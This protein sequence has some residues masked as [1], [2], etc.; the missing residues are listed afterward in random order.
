MLEL[1]TSRIYLS[2]ILTWWTDLSCYKKPFYS[3]GVFCSTW[4]ELNLCPSWKLQTPA[5]HPALTFLVFHCK[6]PPLIL[7]PTFSS[8]SPF[9]ASTFPRCWWM[10]SR[11]A[12]GQRAGAREE[13]TPAAVIPSNDIGRQLFLRAGNE[14]KLVP[15]GLNSTYFWP[16]HSCLDTWNTES[17]E[18]DCRV[19]GWRICPSVVWGSLLLGTYGQKLLLP[20]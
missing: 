13:T 11:K 10:G 19:C 5:P 1:I 9:T 17:N 16:F 12:A 3:A 7:L 2:H 15:N 8:Q 4:A 20:G 14:T 6:Q 18:Q